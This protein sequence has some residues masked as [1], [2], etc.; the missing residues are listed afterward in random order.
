MPSDSAVKI[1]KAWYHDKEDVDAQES[2][3]VELSEFLDSMG[4]GDAF[5][6]VK[7]IADSHPNGHA[8]FETNCHTCQLANEALRKAGLQ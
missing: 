2:W 3:I 5:A 7:R 8:P 4:V 6:F 1:A